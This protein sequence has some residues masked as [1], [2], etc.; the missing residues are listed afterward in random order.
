MVAL[1]GELPVQLAIDH[2]QQRFD[3]DYRPEAELLSA[4]QA[5]RGQPRA[6]QRGTAETGASGESQ[7]LERIGLPGEYR[8]SD[9]G[10]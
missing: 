8:S 4:R 3:D 9:K 7:Q 5:N 2:G 1:G 6:Y 10:P